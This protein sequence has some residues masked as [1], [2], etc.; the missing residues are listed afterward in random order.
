M[1]D[2]PPKKRVFCLRIHPS[3][4]K[5]P[6]I[7][8]RSPSYTVTLHDRSTYLS[9]QHTTMSS[10][11]Q[12][13]GSNNSGHNEGSQNTNAQPDAPL[14]PTRSVPPLT[15]RLTIL[16]EFFGRLPGQHSFWVPHLDTIADLKMRIRTAFEIIG[17]ITF[18]LPPTGPVFN[19][20]GLIGN[21]VL[22]GTDVPCAY[23][24]RNTHMGVHFPSPSSSRRKPKPHTIPTHDVD[25][26]QLSLA[27]RLRLG[28]QLTPM[29]RSAVPVITT[30]SSL[31]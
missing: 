4:P 18:T 27:E 30:D 7:H 31:P 21:R 15:G 22:P 23:L 26:Q 11:P 19:R 2:S 28:Q 5:V 9:V 6:L 16:L 29:R 10:T 8:A 24:T 25:G 13:D 17:A 14:S 20:H 1:I 12:R 3:H